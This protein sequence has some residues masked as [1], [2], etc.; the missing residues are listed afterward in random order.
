MW[1][2][3]EEINLPRLLARKPNHY[4]PPLGHPLS[5]TLVAVMEE[6]TR[7]I[8]ALEP[9]LN[10]RL[11]KRQSG[12]RQHYD[13]DTMSA[14][15]LTGQLLVG[16]P[17]R[18]C[19]LDDETTPREWRATGDLV[20]MVNGK[21]YYLC[22]ARDYLVKLNGKKINLLEVTNVIKSCPIVLDAA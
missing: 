12:M 2:T 15:T 16:G 20:R 21:L 6:H 5:G 9:Y 17:H 1:A 18:M 4:V 7:R 11:L 3:L 8:I 22:R 10:Q 14:H 13:I 19:R